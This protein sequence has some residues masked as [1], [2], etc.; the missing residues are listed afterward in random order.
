MEVGPAL[1]HHVRDVQVPGP[2]AGQLA[3][4][5]PLLGHPVL[6]TQPAVTAERGHRE[7]PG[8]LAVAC[9]GELHRPARGADQQRP[10]ADGRVHRP[11]VHGHQHVAG[12]DRHARRRQR[13]P[14][15]RV[16]GFAGQY[17]VDAPPAVRRRGQVRAEQ[18]HLALAAARGA[19]GPDVG[20]G[21]AQLADDLPHQVGEL[22]RRAN[23]VQHRPVGLQDAGPVHPGH[24]G[25]PEV[26]LHEPAGLGE[27][28]SPEGD[29]VGHEP[30]PGQVDL[31]A[32][33]PVRV[34]LARGRD[35][36]QLARRPGP[37]ATRRRRWTRTSPARRP[38]PWSSGGPDRSV[39]ARTAAAWRPAPRHPR[40][41][42]R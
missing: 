14:R 25:D 33:R 22:R 10:G 11:P 6:V 16:G 13:S 19:P 2:A 36:P 5:V 24:V 34:G 29:R 9:H 21:G 3:D 4:P 23:P 15:P 31:H 1:P 42:P 12:P 26:V 32:V 41:A 28:V 40:R 18:A 7:P 38:A 27:R 17:P 8:W 35:D 30:G 37:P 39:P 20:V